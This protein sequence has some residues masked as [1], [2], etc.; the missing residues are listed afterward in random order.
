[1]YCP[2][3]GGHFKGG[4]MTRS[5]SHR[6]LVEPLEGRTLFSSEINYFFPFVGTLVHRNHTVA[7]LSMTI[8]KQDNNVLTGEMDVRFS[9]H[10]AYK[11][12]FATPLKKARISSGFSD[13]NHSSMKLTFTTFLHTGGGI[14]PAA[15]AATALTGHG[16]FA[17][18]AGTFNM[19]VLGGI[20]VVG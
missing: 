11:Y 16:R 2:P 15:E 13:A 5:E 17:N 6:A 12:T 7:R 3:Y 20:P 9:K 10:V 1:M 14:D 4:T 8:T 19:Q 18:Y